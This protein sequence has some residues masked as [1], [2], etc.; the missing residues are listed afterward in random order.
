MVE[1][2]F[3]YVPINCIITNTLIKVPILIWDRSLTIIGVIS[4]IIKNLLKLLLIHF[5]LSNYK[6]KLVQFALKLIRKR[7]KRR[8]VLL[9]PCLW[10]SIVIFIKCLSPSTSKPLP[11]ISLLVKSL[12]MI[13]TMANLARMPSRS[14]TRAW[15]T[16]ISE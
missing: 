5:L 7:P 10:M 14:W 9:A 16:A 1:P 4:L 6:I 3:I 15:S 2:M 8:A 11:N 12:E 13:T